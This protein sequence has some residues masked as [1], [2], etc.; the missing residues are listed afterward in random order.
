MSVAGRAGAQ[1]A[2]AAVGPELG[3]PGRVAISAERLFG[4][5]YSSQKQ[6]LNGVD[7]PTT[8]TTGFSLLGSPLGSVGGSFSVPRLA[9]DAFVTQGL[10]VGGAVG[11]GYT[12]ESASQAGV[13]AGDL[14]FTGFTI[15]PR[16]GYL[17]RISPGFAVWP[18]VGVSLFYL[19]LS[20]SAQ[21]GG[22]ATSTSETLLAATLEVPFAVTVVPRVVFLFGPTADISVYG[23]ATTNPGG[24]ATSTS[25][26]LSELEIGVH[27]GLLVLL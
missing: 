2:D 13:T 7:G 20:S 15:D 3:Q 16:I 25:T 10:S 8:T 11:V 23:K 27:A 22:T 5:A 6:S 19:S 18:R 21:G 26:D 9:L 4:F 1:G 24:G 17:V 12:K 14:T